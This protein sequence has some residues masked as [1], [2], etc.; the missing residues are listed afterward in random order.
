MGKLS[1]L[2]NPNISLLKLDGLFKI[3]LTGNISESVEEINKQYSLHYKNTDDAAGI[4]CSVSNGKYIVLIS[5]DSKKENVVLTNEVFFI[6]MHE[7][8]HI[9]SFNNGTVII[10]AKTPEELILKTALDLWEEYYASKFVISLADNPMDY[11]IHGLIEPYTKHLK[12]ISDEI[13]FQGCSDIMQVQYLQTVL[14]KLGYIVGSLDGL[15]KNRPIPEERDIEFFLYKFSDDA[16]LLIKIQNE[17]RRLYELGFSWNGNEE[18]KKLTN[19]I[20]L[21][22]NGMRKYLRE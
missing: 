4:A 13:I 18:L 6:L 21:L 9:H 20:I 15:E 1:I 10:E 22:L 14:C 12:E 16:N 5:I 19:I 8:A 2:N 7:L 11:I 3:I 17:L